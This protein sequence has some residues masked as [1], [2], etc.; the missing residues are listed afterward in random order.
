MSSREKS[1]M[2]KAYVITL[3]FRSI[4]SDSGFF[5]YPVPK[6]GIPGPVGSVPEIPRTQIRLILEPNTLTI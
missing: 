6:L 2:N 5:T 4:K 3:Q 1:L